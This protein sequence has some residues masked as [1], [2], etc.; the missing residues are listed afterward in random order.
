MESLELE[1]FLKLQSNLLKIP[2]SIILDGH[3]TFSTDDSP[4]KV[5]D[6]F[7]NFLNEE[8][9]YETIEENQLFGT[10]PLASGGH[11]CIGPVFI[12]QF[13]PNE[14]VSAFNQSH[15]Q[16]NKDNLTFVS[17]NEV[18]NFIC[19]C[20]L[21]INRK[22]IQV[23]DLENHY[24]LSDHKI[25]EKIK[26][27]EG[28]RI[29]E[30]QFKEYSTYYSSDI[31]ERLSWYVRRGNVDGLRQNLQHEVYQL[32]RLATITLRHLKNATL[33][34]NS[35]VLR[36]AIK[37]GLDKATAYRLGAIY[38]QKIENCS[39]VDE[40]NLVS[41]HMTIDY[42]ERVY[43]HQ[44]TNKYGTETI[45]PSIKRCMN[46]INDHYSEA[47]SLDQLANHVGYSAPY[48]SKKFKETLNIS[49]TEFINEKRCSEAQDRLILT[50]L[51]L[52]EI[53]IQVGYSSQ[54][55]FQKK[56]KQVVGESPQSFRVKN[57]L[58]K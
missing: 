14:D 18:L 35:L 26:H 37:G 13:L 46:Y 5:L 40:L 24:Q 44:Q 6:W 7:S 55:Y 30:E 41:T 38:A 23:D 58:I 47:I 42:C 11:L 43:K 33:I 4:E 21:V 53:A 57:S 9:Y 29:I 50:D 12:N 39:N 51:S 25:Q 28:L 15:V 2:C 17:C 16:A 34:K 49:L 48:L 19:L 45:A 56:F 3:C 54:S 1:H 36:A 32:E 20:Q 8:I 31:V 22:I 27:E 10:V 52:F